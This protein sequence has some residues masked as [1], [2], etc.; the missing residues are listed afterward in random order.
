MQC[1][2]LRDW[3]I[4]ATWMLMKLSYKCKRECLQDWV[5][6]AMWLLARW[7]HHAQCMHALQPHALVGGATLI[8]YRGCGLIG[9]RGGSN[10]P[11]ELPLD[12]PLI[13][14]G[15]FVLAPRPCFATSLVCEN[16]WHTHEVLSR[17]AHAWACFMT[18]DTGLLTR[19]LTL[20]IPDWFKIRPTSL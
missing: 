10:E 4:N 3:V 2:C 16:R 9:G 18:V 1:E 5:I 19:Y 15:K 13:N 14:V 6:N 20:C 7:R 8:D 12:P 11:N 17:A